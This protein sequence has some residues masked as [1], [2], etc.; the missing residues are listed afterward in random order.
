MSHVITVPCDGDVTMTATGD[1][2]HLCPHVDEIDN[3]AIHI[4][5][6]VAG[7]TYELHSL[8]EYLRGFK[9]SRISHEEI[10]D[11]IR[12]DLSTVNGIELISV[13]TTWDTAGLEVSCSTS[14]TRAAVTP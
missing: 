13:V 4:E 7:Q 11:R 9:D 5:W 2:T 8:A 10:T 1:L 6:R 3:G 14:P 12:H